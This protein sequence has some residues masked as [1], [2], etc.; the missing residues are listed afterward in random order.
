MTPRECE[1]L[2]GLPD[3]HTL[4]PWRGG[5][6]P[7]SRRYSAIGNSMAVP[8]IEWVLKRVRRQVC[9]AQTADRVAA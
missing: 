5:W 7:D 4:V 8:V 9:E 2:Q 3:D 6:A 1:R